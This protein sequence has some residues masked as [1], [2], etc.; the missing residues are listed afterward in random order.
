[1]ARKDPSD[2]WV[3]RLWTSG[4]ERQR[5]RLNAAERELIILLAARA[6]SAGVSPDDALDLALALIDALDLAPQ[7]P[8]ERA[9]LSARR[10]SR[11]AASRIA[12][13][14][15]GSCPRRRISSSRI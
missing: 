4:R 2:P 10:A 5:R 9:C 15:R 6:R 12:L 7:Y 8:A 14:P 1:M 3:R 11:S 13:G